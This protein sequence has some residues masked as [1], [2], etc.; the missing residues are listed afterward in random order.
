MQVF[1][2]ETWSFVSKNTFKA[3]LNK[4]IDISLTNECLEQLQKYVLG[5]RGYTRFFFF[6]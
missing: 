1:L 6:L 3:N 4:S 2:M 5:I